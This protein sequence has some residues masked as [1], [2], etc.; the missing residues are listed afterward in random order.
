MNSKL[1]LISLIALSGCVQKPT[2]VDPIQYNLAE[3]AV[4]PAMC[5]TPGQSLVAVDC[6]KGKVLDAKALEAPVKATV[7]G[8]SVTFNVNEI[9][10]TVTTCN[11]LAQ[12]IR[13]RMAIGFEL[14]KQKPAAK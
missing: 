14:L 3:L 10:G 1:M 7:D 9:V 12:Q 11:V 8:C 13:D 4:A 2:P 5:V 6:P